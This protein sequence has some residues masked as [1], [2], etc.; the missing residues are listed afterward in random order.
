MI[1]L[2]DGCCEPLVCLLEKNH[3]CHC[4]NSGSLSGL[5][6]LWFLPFSFGVF[7]I[8]IDASLSLIYC[9]LVGFVV[10]LIFVEPILAHKEGKVIFR[11]IVFD[12]LSQHQPTIL[13]L[14]LIVFIDTILIHATFNG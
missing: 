5:W 11:T 4:L 8:K 12:S 6:V 13:N 3:Y 2:M 9:C 1:F 10:G 7:L 14:L